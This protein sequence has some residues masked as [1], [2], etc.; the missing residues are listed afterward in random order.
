MPTSCTKCPQCGCEAPEQS[1]YAKVPFLKPAPKEA[2]EK[3]SS[4]EE[5]AILTFEPKYSVTKCVTSAITVA[6]ICIVAFFFLLNNLGSSSTEQLVRTGYYTSY[7]NVKIEDAF[8]QFFAEPKWSHFTSTDNR[9]IVEFK[10]KCQYDNK[11]AN[12]LLQFTVDSSNN[13]FN[14]SAGSINDEPQNILVLN[15]LISNVLGSYQ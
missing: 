11:P 10:G 14:L 12:V 2:S 3:K 6:V 1:I 7:P 15:L 8:A 13:S 4:T 9:Q 5:E